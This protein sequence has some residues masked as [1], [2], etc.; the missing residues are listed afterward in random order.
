MEVSKAF[1]NLSLDYISMFKYVL[2]ECRFDRNGIFF[3]LC[4]VEVEI[5]KSNRKQFSG[6][7][8][9]NHLYKFRKTH[10]KIIYV[11]QTHKLSN[12]MP[13]EIF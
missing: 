7:L 2:N 6:K 8:R 10:T 11:C 9:R 5:L 4:N 13:N 1:I 12:C 3:E